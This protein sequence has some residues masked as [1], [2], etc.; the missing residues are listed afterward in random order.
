MPKSKRKEAGSLSE[1]ERQK[2]QRLYMQGGAAYGSVRNLVKDSILPVSKARQVLHSKHSYAKFTIAAREF[3]RI[4][5][6]PRF[7]NEIWCMDPVYVDNLAKTNNGVKYL[8]VRQDLFDRTVHAEGMKT[9]DSKETVCAFLSMITKKN[10][11]EK[12]WVHK[13]GNLLESLGNYGNLKEYKCTLQ[14]VTLRLPSLNVQYDL[15]KI[16]FTVTWKFMDTSTFTKCL[17]SSQTWIP[18][19]IARWT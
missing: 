7:K 5:A 17:N 6:F 13:G 12:V 18:E 10:R 2:L 8:L 3:K 11:P 9:K 19:K 4:K 15:W 16:Y 1:N 14:W